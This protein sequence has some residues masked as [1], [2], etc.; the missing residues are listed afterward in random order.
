MPQFKPIP[1]SYSELY[2]SLFN[3]HVVAPFYSKPLQLRILNAKK[4]W[5][6]FTSMPYLKTI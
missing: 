3:A 6:M 1:M 5:E 2:Q 4:C